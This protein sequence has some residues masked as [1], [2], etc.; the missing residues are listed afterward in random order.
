[1]YRGMLRIRRFESAVYRL[2][3]QGAIPGTVHLYAG[4]EAV[5]VGVC[6]NLRDNDY[7]LSTHRGHGHYIAKGCDLKRLMAEL[8][9]RV[10]GCCK[11]KGGSM[12]VGEFSKGMLPAIA[13]VGANVPVG[14]GVALSFK[15]RDTDQVAACFFGD[16]AVNQGMWH[17]GVNLAAVW[18]LPLILVCENNFYAASTH[19]SKS[20]RIERVSDRA[21]AYGIK[22]VTVDG[23]DVLAVYEAA[24]EAVERA[25]NGEGP[26]LIECLT[27]R[28]GG[29]SRGDPATYRPKDEVEEWLKRDPIPRFKA[30]LI[31]W[32]VLKPEEAEQ[33]ESEV[34]DEIR[35][36]V[37]F[38][39]ASPWPRPE[40]ALEDTYPASPMN[41][42]E[43]GESRERT[44]TIGEAIREALREEMRRDERVFLIGE[45]IGVKGGFGGPFGVT[46][47]LSDEFGPERVRDTPVSESAIVGAAVGAAVMG[48]KPIAEV[49]YGDFAFC[50][51][52]QIVNEAAKLRYM[53]GGQVKVPMVLRVPTGATGRGAQHAQ[54]PEAFFLHVPELKVAAP[55]TPY[56]AKGLLKTA[57]RSEDGPVIFFE[58]KLLYGSKGYRSEKAAIQVTGPVPEGDYLIPFGKARIRREG[59]DVTIICKLLMVY[60]SL[61][62]A[63]RLSREG[64]EAE[65][66]DPRTL[67]PFD[68]D[69][70][71]ESLKKTG[72]LVI[73]EED[74]RTNGW[75]AEVAATIAEEA[76]DYLDAPIRRVSALD[77]PIPATPPLERFV[78][79]DEE[80]IIKAVKE[81]T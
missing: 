43:P 63:E 56:D 44:L 48:L 12:H 45:D 21:S 78:I 30:R 22:G 79:P 66:I 55:S 53:S 11:G 27:Y 10:G 40:V 41:V 24:G 6:S 52:D 65:V 59:G 14:A 28:H 67:I 29:H 20:L 3:L 35:R 39:E 19:I 16:G 31:E 5:A 72:R 37:E 38:A 74:N 46:L 73:V 42:E 50:A 25:R 51:M 7:I 57:I 18:D 23:N 17:E 8:Y 4:E 33:M 26:T 80:K 58:H 64:I 13:I 49:Q 60:K 77:L 2:F 71:L 34:E 54:S 69:T 68:K 36:A 75:G 81:I 1:M 32:G 70:L 9:G 15:M 76:M 47:G 62:A 61:A